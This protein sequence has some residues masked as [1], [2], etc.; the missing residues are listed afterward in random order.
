LHLRNAAYLRHFQPLLEE[1]LS[2]GHRISLLF[3]RELERERPALERMLSHPRVAAAPAQAR[4]EPSRSL[5]LPLRAGVD[6]LRYFEPGFERAW[7]LRSRQEARAPRWLVALAGR[8][9]FGN[10]RARR[11]CAGL[12]AYLD[13]GLPAPPEVVAQLRE[14]QPDLVL[15]APL[16]ADGDQA[17]VVRAARRLA[18]PCGLLVASWDNLTNKGLIR[19]V[20]DAVLLWNDVQRDEATRLHAV[21][22]ERIAM[23][24]AHTFDPWFARRP[25]E[26]RA[27]FCARLGFDPERP[28]VLYLCSSVAIAR[29]EPA[30]VE[31]WLRFLRDTGLPEPAEANVLIR[32][33]PASG[34]AWRDSELAGWERVAV[35]PPVGSSPTD[36]ASQAGFYDSMFH[37]AAVVGINTSAIIE[38]AIV[39]RE[40]F[41]V[42]VDEFDGGQEG[43]VHFSYLRAETG[44]PLT[45]AADLPEHARQLA[46]ALRGG[47]SPD[48]LEAFVARFVRPLGLDRAA[49]PIAADRLEALAG[50]RRPEAGRVSAAPGPLVAGLVAGVSGA[51][52]LRAR[53]GPQSP[54]RQRLRR[55]RR[56]RR[57]RR[58]AGQPSRR[59]GPVRRRVL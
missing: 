15:V 14:L 11:A 34:G 7:F 2:R 25:S 31:R 56:R 30:W 58:R 39:G 40:G 49:A 3:Q 44:G 16:V 20:P 8:G 1:L 29:T 48:R 19:D 23:T 54:W 22:P 21:P 9:L 28:I 38:S 10:A 50:E 12:L 55:E 24:G 59:G 46:A 4:G 27:T 17:D 26:D 37:A 57:K 32:P 47:G 52:R 35:W 33:H 42:L 6:Y 53:L 36:A 43:T 18:I 45:V 51:Q 41:T 13:R 5:A